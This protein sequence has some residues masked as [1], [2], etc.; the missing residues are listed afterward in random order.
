MIDPRNYEAVR[1]PFPDAETPPLWCYT[2]RAFYRR[3]VERI[4]HK[5]WN[6]V[7]DG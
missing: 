1:R 2:S 6:R 3:E 7:L 5:V 4:F